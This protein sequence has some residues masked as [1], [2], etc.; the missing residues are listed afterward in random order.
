[1]RPLHAPYVAIFAALALLACSNDDRRDASPEL[2]T[3]SATL[4]AALQCSDNFERAALDPVLLVHGTALDTASNFSWNWIPAFETDER[5][6]C[7]VDLPDKGLADI[8]ESAEY[9]VFALRAMQARRPQPVHI[10]GYSQGGMLPRWVLKYF[11]DTRDAVAGLVSLSGSHHGTVL[12]EQLGVC[13]TPCAP[14]FHQQ[15]AGSR[16]MAALNDGPETLPGIDYSSI[17]TRLDEVV[18]P[19][20]GEDASS[21][22]RGGD[23]ERVRN[24]ALQAVCPLNVSEHLRIGTSDA[25]AYALAVDAFDHPG[26]ADPQRLDAG[27]CAALLMPGVNPLTFA[28]DFALAGAAIAQNIATGPMVAEEPPLRCYAGGDCP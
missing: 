21:R 25:L 3:D 9:V 15:A 2:R 11:P 23:P 20:F 4:E 22:L 18:V 14:S 13:A 28:T 17:W 6:Y 19:N 8:Q 10:L 27:I 16:F 7:T 5:P 26:P 24:I 12:S 1:M